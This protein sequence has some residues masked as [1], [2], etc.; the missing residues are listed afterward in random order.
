VSSEY[1]FASAR[2]VVESLANV[3]P[4]IM[5]TAPVPNAVLLPR[6]KVPPLKVDPPLKV[7]EP[8]SVN[9]PLPLFTNAGVVPVPVITPL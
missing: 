9:A 2:A 4:P 6:N 7:F 5:E 8:L 3:T 1:A